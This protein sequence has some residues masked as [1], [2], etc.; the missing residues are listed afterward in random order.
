[1]TCS[2]SE[3]CY[4]STKS[5]EYKS[6]VSK[7]ACR[8]ISAPLPVSVKF[9]WHSATPFSFCTLS[10]ATLCYNGRVELLQQ[11]SHGLQRHVIY[12]LELCRKC[13]QTSTLYC[14]TNG[15]LVTIQDQP[16]FLLHYSFILSKKPFLNLY[17]SKI[18]I[19]PSKFRS[20]APL[21]INLPL[22]QLMGSS[23][24]Y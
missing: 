1:M 9:F 15:S 13:L 6:A 7:L 5:M 20:T 2:H 18:L 23:L 21:Q 12:S 3:A 10:I 4:S 14:H 24:L 16:T 11:R 17:P 19:H 8:P 22:S